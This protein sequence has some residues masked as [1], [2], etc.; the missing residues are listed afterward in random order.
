MEREEEQE[1]KDR[2]DRDEFK[3]DED[4][5]Q[6]ALS[7]LNYT[8]HRRLIQRD[9]TVRPRE[10]NQ[11]PERMPAR[12]PRL[13]P[14]TSKSSAGTRGRSLATADGQATAGPSSTA[15]GRR[16]IPLPEPHD[17]SRMVLVDSTPSNA[18]PGRRPSTGPAVGT[19]VP[20][21]AARASRT[22]EESTPRT[23]PPRG[24]LQANRPG[25]ARIRERSEDSGAASGGGPLAH[26]AAGRGDSTARERAQRRL[27]PTISDSVGTQIGG[28][29]LSRS[30]TP[31]RVAAGLYSTNLPFEGG[32]P[33]PD[34]FDDLP[35][36]CD[37]SDVEEGHSKPRNNK[38]ERGDSGRWG[39][40]FAAVQRGA[41]G[42]LAGRS[43]G[44]GQRNA[45]E[46]PGRA[47]G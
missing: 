39:G 7:T 16:K 37:D 44:P 2:A 24:N 45:G 17:L 46:P 40:P 6:L 28:S 23:S 41:S 31:I 14:P 10:A 1:R 26:A 19:K 12:R 15:G 18:S 29:G 4:R 33:R 5:Q 47:G 36:L 11:V 43:G 42:P 3:N 21:A 30:R 22:S 34:I 25:P 27:G 32:A 38:S 8:Q 20:V 35:H 13:D 9:E